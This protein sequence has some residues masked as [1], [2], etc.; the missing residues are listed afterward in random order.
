MNRAIG[1]SLWVLV[2][3]ALLGCGPL[4]QPS[5]QL[6]A[7]VGTPVRYAGATQRGE[8]L[9]RSFMAEHRIPGLSVSVAVEGA[10]VWSDG[11]GYADLE[12]RIAVTPLTRF[13]I[14]SVSKPVTAAVIG[15]LY[16]DGRLDLDVPVQRYA[17]S[18]PRK[19]WPVTTRQLAGHLGGIRSYQGQE[20]YSARPYK[21]VLEGLSIFSQDPLLHEPGTKYSYSSYGY[22][23]I[24]AVIEGVSGQE[25]L[26]YVRKTVFEPLGMRSIAADRNDQLIPYRASFYSRDDEGRPVNAPYVD[27]SYKWA[28]GGFISDTADLVRFG[29]AHLSGELLESDTVRELFSTQRTKDGEA[30]N[31]GIGWGMDQ[32]PAGRRRVSHGGSSVG[33]R[34]ILLL[35]PAQKLVVAVLVN[36]APAPID[37]QLAQRISEP[38]LLEMESPAAR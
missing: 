3:A 9:V 14:G 34:A 33:G 37:L 31:Y 27:N 32:D 25:F 16:Q 19:S 26:T 10:I 18:F 5:S 17:P 13:R 7:Q 6:Q 36:V 15:K 30:T 20:M 2:V 1:R 28:G 23:L 38:F 4:S 35:Y 21:N 22:N 8:A 24:S 11:F 29:S 12:H